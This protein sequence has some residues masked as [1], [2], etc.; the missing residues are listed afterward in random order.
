MRKKQCTVSW[1]KS[2]VTISCIVVSGLSPHRR[3]VEVIA[4]IEPSKFSIKKAGNKKLKM[5]HTCKKMFV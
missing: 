2:I 1:G 3:T 5:S 4:P